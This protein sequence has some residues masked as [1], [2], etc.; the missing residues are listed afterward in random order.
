M[1]VSN[2]F[3]VAKQTVKQTAQLFC[4]ETCKTLRENNSDAPETAP[5]TMPKTPVLFITALFVRVMESEIFYPRLTEIT[6]IHPL[7][8]G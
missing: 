6:R 3:I 7:L 8:W 4:A 5:K 2:R 1:V